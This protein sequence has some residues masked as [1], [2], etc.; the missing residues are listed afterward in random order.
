MEVPARGPTQ[1]G[2]FGGLGRPRVARGAAEN[3]RASILHHT[4]YSASL[5][6]ARPHWS[7]ALSRFVADLLLV[8]L[9]VCLFHLEFWLVECEY[10]QFVKETFFAAV[11]EV[12]N[13]Y[14]FGNAVWCSATLQY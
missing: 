12:N 13:L 5:L 6:A 2:P 10:C 4:G 7:F 11:M 3:V 9:F 1:W 14:M 8:C